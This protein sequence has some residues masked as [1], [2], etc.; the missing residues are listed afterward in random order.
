MRLSNKE[1]LALTN[2]YLELIAGKPL[3]DREVHDLI[4]E[5]VESYERY[6]NRGFLTYRKSVTESGQFAALEWSGSGSVLQDALGRRYIDCLGGYGIFSAGVN[7][8]RIVKAVTDQLQRM[9]LN[10]QEL[11]EPW[12][13]GLAKVLAGVTPG[14]LSC[15]FF[16][17]NGTDAI[18]GAIKLA[19]LHTKRRVFLSTLG[20]FHGKSLGSL[21]LMGKATFR[22]PFA[23]GLQD[24]RFV[25]FG[26]AAALEAEFAKA[27]AI[28]NPFAGFVVEPV[29][30]EAGAVV[31]PAGYLRKARDLCTRYGT[32]LIADEVQTGLG[33]TG[34]MWGVDHSDVVPDI[35]CLGKSL[36]GGVMPLSAF[37]STPA[38]WECL[39]PNPVIHSTT[40]GGNPL[41]CAAGI[42]AISV[43]L[44]EDLPAQAA[45]KGEMLL[46]ELSRLQR[47]YPDVLTE[48]RGKGLL[49]GLEFPSDSIGYRFAAGLF[50]RGVLVAGT[51]SKA[52]TVRIEPALGIADELLNEVLGRIEDT[53]REIA[54]TLRVKEPTEVETA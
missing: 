32:L 13:A 9:A 33:R 7:H 12:R 8:P 15:S 26:D 20:G 23:S 40:F 27:D 42:A 1:S 28:G 29:Q 52:R 38:I 53:L 17:N 18:E 6:V 31:P 19:R 14:D 47:R 30:G 39:V 10:S 36:G 22:E 35:L 5:T 25:P 21:S 34:A 41:A 46:R 49:I 44:E 37:V 16:I 2:R 43:T 54:A 24:V 11:L 48:A 50:K 45:R 4:Q 3:A 51:Y